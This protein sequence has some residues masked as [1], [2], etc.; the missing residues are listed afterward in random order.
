MI[1]TLNGDLKSGWEIILDDK[2]KSLKIEMGVLDQDNEIPVIRAEGT[3]N[4]DVLTTFR[5]YCNSDN[6]KAYDANVSDFQYQKQLG[7]N[8]I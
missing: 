4:H 2:K 8:L 1:K 6:R 7:V 3:Q 5:C